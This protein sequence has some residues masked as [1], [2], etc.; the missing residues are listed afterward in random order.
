MWHMNK[1]V[2]KGAKGLPPARILKTDVIRMRVSADH[3][4]AFTAS[5]DREGLELSAWL[6][7]LALRAAGI[8]PEAK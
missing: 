4:K 3:K 2:R 7:Q 1:K 5:A 8:L 6:R